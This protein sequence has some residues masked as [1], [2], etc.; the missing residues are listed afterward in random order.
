MSKSNR[1]DES[2][3]ENIGVQFN[4]ATQK[5]FTAKWCNDLLTNLTDSFADI[6]HCFK[7]L[8]SDIKTLESTLFDKISEVKDV[9]AAAQRSA[10]ANA[11]AINELKVDFTIMK[12]D[13][14][15]LKHECNVLNNECKKLRT[16]NIALKEQSTNLE[17]YSRKNNV[18]LRGITEVKDENNSMCEETVRL[19]LKSKLDIE[20]VCVDAMQF[21]R[22]H[23]LRGRKNQ[24]ARDVIVRF[25]SL[26]DKDIVWGAQSKLK[27]TKYGMNE[28]FP[29]E[30][31]NNRRKLYPIFNQARRV[32]PK[33]N[34]SLKGDKLNINGMIYTVSSLGRLQGVLHTSK[35]N[36]KSNDEVLVFGGVLSDYHRFSNWSPV[37][38]TYKNVTFPTLEHAYMHTMATTFHDAE[39]AAN[40]LGAPDAQCAKQLS[41]SIQGFNAT[42]WNDKKAGVMKE[43][44]RIKFSQGTEHL[45]QL[46]ATGNKSLAETGKNSYYACGLS[47]TDKDILDKSKW[48][49]NNLGLMLEEIRREART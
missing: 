26:A 38:L 28:D 46:L 2:D 45:K 9:A 8:K 1:S 27:M 34:V 39:A 3:A 5:T 37:Q 6:K 49:G 48:S 25:R 31:A 44:L 43:L 15:G 21:Q 30:V 36:E 18:I 7:D 23:R 29:R 33:R 13:Y 47:I 14:T 41:Y 22:C 40:I 20:S 4:V 32:L 19:F 17:I 42:E 16:E 35:F 11:V 24:H 10:D 12:N